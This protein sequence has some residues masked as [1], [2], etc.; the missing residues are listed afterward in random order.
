VRDL[1]KAL[2]SILDWGLEERMATVKS[3]MKIYQE[4]QVGL[5]LGLEPG[6]K[7]EARGTVLDWS[8]C[9]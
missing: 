5:P 8:D 4:K 9:S 2:H 7:A 1:R 3:Q 6:G